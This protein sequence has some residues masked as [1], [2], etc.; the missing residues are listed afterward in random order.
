M[1]A[2]KLPD[3]DKNNNFDKNKDKI[4]TNSKKDIFNEDKTNNNIKKDIF[5]EDKTNNNIKKDIF[6]EDKINTNSKKDAQ[7]GKTNGSNIADIP[8]AIDTDI[9][10]ISNIFKRYS[11]ILE[12]SDKESFKWQVQS[13]EAYDVFK[14]SFDELQ[15]PHTLYE[16]ITKKIGIFKFMIPKKWGQKYINAFEM[17]HIYSIVPRQVVFVAFLLFVLS[18]ILCFGIFVFAADIIYAGLIFI[19]CMLV[20]LFYIYY[21]F[22]QEKRAIQKFN[23]TAPIALLYII[24]YLKNEPVLENA[25]FFTSTR[26]EGPLAYQ[27]RKIL[28]DLSHSKYSSLDS[29]LDEYIKK[30]KKWS[31]IFVSSLEKVQMSFFEST[32]SDRIKRYDY[33]M[34]SMLQDIHDD[35]QLFV[36][37]L[38][39]P[40]DIINMMGIMLPMMIS[41]M[42]PMIVMFMPELIKPG[43]LALLYDLVLPFFI[44]IVVYILVSNRPGFG[45]VISQDLS[46]F[47][48]SKF[49][50]IKLVVILLI[51]ASPALVFFAAFYSPLG[52]H[53]VQEK[54]LNLQVSSNKYSFLPSDKVDFTIKGLNSNIMQITNERLSKENKVKYVLGNASALKNQITIAPCVENTNAYCVSYRL[55]PQQQFSGLVGEHNFSANIMLADGT[56]GK[57]TI[58]YLIKQT[59]IL[60]IFVVITLFVAIVWFVRNILGKIVDAYKKESE[61]VDI[62][63]R[64]LSVSFYQLSTLLFRGLPLETSIQ[65]IVNTTETT[66]VRVFFDRILKNMTVLKMNFEDALYNSEIGALNYAPSKLI[67]DLLI[68]V[69]KTVDKGSQNLARTLASLSVYLR[70]MEK[71]NTQIKQEMADTVSSMKINIYLLLPFIS[72]TIINFVF[73]IGT[74]FNLIMALP[75]LSIA[76]TSEI[77]S[78]SSFT[79]AGMFGFKIYNSLPPDLFAAIVGIYFIT[80][81]IIISYF[82]SYIVYGDD[83]LKFAESL[84]GN[85]LVSTVIFIVILFGM[86]MIFSAISNQLTGVFVIS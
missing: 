79:S 39:T 2:P 83:I 14:K 54:N 43:Y 38:K 62:I 66:E 37:G 42:I 51:I 15:K 56:V 12:R 11:G 70:N 27:L 26:L 6:N 4:N 81:I 86:S 71:I 18:L 84:K 68:I 21:P 69:A 41:I 29:A 48:L 60:W 78:M 64:E 40:T 30:W 20:V 47:N 28:W 72:A 53:V 36:K 80:S 49:Q 17:L 35:T 50:I 16:K 22:I 63:E 65:H 5:N 13:R 10:E 3:R 67:Y 1:I 24:V 61:N 7:T 19:F 25:L 34:E 46:K 85:M 76:D 58:S 59:T 9:A 74:V 82:A 55:P 73:L 32:E 45:G 33:I 31:P 8:S 77:S 52:L 23:L 75:E 57:L 44:L